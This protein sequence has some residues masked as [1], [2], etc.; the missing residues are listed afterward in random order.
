MIFQFVFNA[1][2]KISLKTFEIPISRNCTFEK[3]PVPSQKYI[4]VVNGVKKFSGYKEL[5]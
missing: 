2:D 4:K 3:R 1:K 5:M